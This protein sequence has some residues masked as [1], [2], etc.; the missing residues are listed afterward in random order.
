MDI[1]RFDIVLLQENGREQ[2]GVVVSP[3]EMNKHLPQVI[4]APVFEEKAAYPTR[5]GG[6]I[7]LEGLKAVSKAQIRQKLGRVKDSTAR[8]LCTVLE[9]MFRY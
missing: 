7:A 5:I 1:R 6:Q 8:D 3:D 9:E 4:I 2:N